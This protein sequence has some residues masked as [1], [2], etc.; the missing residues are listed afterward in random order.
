MIFFQSTASEETLEAGKVT[1]SRGDRQGG[2]ELMHEGVLLYETIHSIFHKD[3]ARAYNSYAIAVHSVYRQALQ[4]QLTADPKTEEPPAFG[5]ELAEAIRLQRQAVI[6]AERTLGLDHHET[7]SF[8][9]NLAMLESLS[10]DAELSLKIFRHVLAL[11]T[12]VFGEGHPEQ[13]ILLTNV[14]NLLSMASQFHDS[15]K[16]FNKHIEL[17]TKVFGPTS[18]QV[19]STHNLLCQTL[20]CIQD[21]EGATANAEAA[22]KIYSERLGEE[23]SSTA[24]AKAL[25]DAFKNHAAQTALAEAQNARRVASIPAAA[26]AATNSNSRRILQQQGPSAASSA[27]PSSS[28]RSKRLTSQEM[29]Q[30]AQQSADAAAADPNIG[31]RGHLEIDDLV[32]FV[33]GKGGKKSKKQ[34]RA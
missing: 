18:I 21:L 30:R 22:Y 27:V 20:F 17:S 6:I 1:I 7:I 25:L 11:G 8:Y 23:D 10:E 34:A 15:V 33:G 9:Q 19:A 24:E 28:S 16:L 32:A 13:L 29:A 5:V 2:L 31:S 4:Q 12:I 26:A 3:V 14:G